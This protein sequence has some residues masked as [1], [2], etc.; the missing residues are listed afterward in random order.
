MFS[1]L[2]WCFQINNVVTHRNPGTLNVTVSLGWRARSWIGS[3][4]SAFKTMPGY[5][6]S[7]CAHILFTHPSLLHF[8]LSPTTLHCTRAV[9]VCISDYRWWKALFVCSAVTRT[10]PLQTAI[11]NFAVFRWA[12]CL[13]LWHWRSLLVHSGPFIFAWISVV[14]Y[15]VCAYFFSL[16]FD[17]LCHKSQCDRYFSF[18]CVVSLL[19]RISTHHRQTVSPL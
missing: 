17:L 10:S 18:C 7:S 13:S 8:F 9:S 6:Q 14:S 16:V 11:P 3:K 1:V 5:F 15:P 2:F 19:R 4:L 12:V